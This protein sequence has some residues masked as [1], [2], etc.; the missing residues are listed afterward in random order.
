[1]FG[2]SPDDRIWHTWQIA[3]DNGWNGGWAELYS[4][5]D[6]LRELRVG[7]DQDGRLEV[8]GV[9]PDDSIWH[10][11]QVAP[12][13]GWVGGWTELGTEIRILI[14]VVTRPTVAIATMLS[15]M[16]NVYATA[17]IRVS[18]GPRENLTIIPAAG[19]PAQTAF[20]VGPC[21]LGQALTPD[22]TLL[23]REPQQRR[24]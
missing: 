14:K 10:T 21:T 11:W 15:N 7:N 12:N 16:R 18:E 24:A 5:A 20:T 6:R 22:Q 19:G 4:P 9:A 23:F 13:N 8:F 1:M 2:V 17:G 3:P